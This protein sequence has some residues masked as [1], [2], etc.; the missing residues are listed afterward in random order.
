VVPVPAETEDVD[1]YVDAFGE[2]LAEL[3]A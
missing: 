2:L 3:T 1:A